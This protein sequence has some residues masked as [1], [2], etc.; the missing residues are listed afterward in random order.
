MITI[1][2]VQ[3]LRV[4]WSTSMHTN[5]IVLF[6]SLARLASTPNLR[7]TRLL[8]TTSQALCALLLAACSGSLTITIGNEPPTLS[9]AA[10]P[11]T[12]SVPG[13]ISLSAIATDN[14]GIR[15]VLFYRLVEN[16]PAQLAQVTTAPYQTTVALG[17]ADNGSVRFFARAFDNEGASADS[18]VITVTVAIP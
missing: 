13:N 3:L 17:R 4:D 8:R 5:I 16:T 12:L 9:L 14:G 11:S 6:C 18:A 2:L 15:E 7:L 10:A 1:Y